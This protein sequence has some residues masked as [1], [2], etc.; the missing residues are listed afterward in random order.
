MWLPGLTRLGARSWQVS[1]KPRPTWKRLSLAL[2]ESGIWR[3]GKMK[4]CPSILIYSNLFQIFPLSGVHAA[5]EA[6]HPSGPCLQSW[7][8]VGRGRSVPQTD[9]INVFLRSVQQSSHCPACTTTTSGPSKSL[10]LLIR[11]LFFFEWRPMM[12][13]NAASPEPGPEIDL[14]SSILGPMPNLSQP[15]Y[16]APIVSRETR[17]EAHLAKI[18]S[19]S[20]LLGDYL[21]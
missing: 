2:T 13:W 10:F 12:E 11:Y 1:M 19:Y 20:L 3:T 21:S 7:L 5:V 15:I 6:G 4:S 16:G 17:N 18:R 9:V 14:G 8:G